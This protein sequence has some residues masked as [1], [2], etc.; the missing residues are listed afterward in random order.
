MTEPH[1][2]PVGLSTASVWPQRAGTGFELAAELGYDGVEVMVWVDQVSQDVRALRRWSADTGMPVL[3]MHSPSLLITQRV[4]SPD[5]EI[6]LRRTVDAALELGAGTVVVHPPFRWQRRYA[7]SFADLVAEL[8]ETSGV[9]VA[10]ENMFKVR[11]PGGGRHSRVSAFRPSIDPTDVGYRHY[12][13]DLSHTAAARMDPLA[14][15]ERMGSGL[16]HVHLADGTGLP[17]DEHLVPGH[18]NQPCAE[19]LEKLTTGGFTGQVVL[20]VNTRRAGQQARRAGDLAEAL[21]FARL[22]LGQ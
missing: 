18:G 20:E 13:L 6:R 4:W 22:H 1:S 7:E 10:V 3:S 5:P 11:P 9:A 2:I 15:A 19:L 12:T 21:L 17:K 16:T 8:E 14:L